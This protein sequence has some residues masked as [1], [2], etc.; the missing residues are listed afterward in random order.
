MAL[1]TWTLS[2]DLTTLLFGSTSLSQPECISAHHP[3][4][5]AW[6]RTLTLHLKHQDRLTVE[7][8][9]PRVFL[10]GGLISYST[11]SCVIFF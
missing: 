3:L 6:S 10:R 7:I 4:E 2:T 9:I 5:G 1:C 8:Q 11:Q